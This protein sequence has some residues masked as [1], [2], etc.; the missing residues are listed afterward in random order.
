MTLGFRAAAHLAGLLLTV[1]AAFGA[2]E[3]KAAV[4]LN[5]SSADFVDAT[6]HDNNP[7]SGALTAIY[8]TADTKI[9]RFDQLTRQL[10]DGSI[11]FVIFETTIESGQ[12]V[13]D[14]LIYD[15]G[16]AAIAAEAQATYKTSPLFDITLQ[17]FDITQ[18]AGYVYWLG[19]MSDTF[20]TI[21]GTQDGPF[22]SGPLHSLEANRNT[23]GFD[24]PT[25]DL[26]TWC[27]DTFVRL[28]D[29]SIAVAEPTT[30]ALSAFVVFAIGV[31]RRT[32]RARIRVGA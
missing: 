9:T 14:A 6:L 4:L 32:R 15:S 18:Q 17:A 7:F 11:K 25:L 20:A 10:V 21:F 2:V 13:S 23:L 1:V 12:I 30:L 31:A 24:T 22:S 5:T 16:A 8:V 3:T 26:E 28:Y 19:M 27:C 29:D